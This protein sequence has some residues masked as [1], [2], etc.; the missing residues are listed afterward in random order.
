MDEQFETI[1]VIQVEPQELYFKNVRKDETF[2]EALII[3]NNSD[4]TISFVIP[5]FINLTLFQRQ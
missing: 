3:T 1:P 2:Q 4:T 5:H